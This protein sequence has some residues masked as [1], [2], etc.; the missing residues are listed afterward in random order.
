MRF[1]ARGVV[2]IGLLVALLPSLGVVGGEDKTN[3]GVVPLSD[4]VGGKTYAQWSAAWWQWALGTPKVNNPLI[5]PTG[6]FAGEGQ[7]G[8]VWFLAGNFGGKTTRSCILPAGKALFFP[9]VNKAEL[10]PP[11]A[12][13][14]KAMRAMAKGFVDS[15]RNL[16]VTVDGKP[17]KNLMQYRVQSGL[18]L[19]NGPKPEE[20]VNPFWSGKQMMVSDG[21]WILLKPL[22]PGEHVIRFKGEMILGEFSLD[23]TYRLK[24]LEAKKP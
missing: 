20:A 14:E 4:K 1:L 22:A 3:P 16:E 6:K 15:A 9:V 19:F 11:G 5:D 13:D 18:F 12:A 17:I 24:V 7:S 8:P 21:Y 23:V 10:G 2:G